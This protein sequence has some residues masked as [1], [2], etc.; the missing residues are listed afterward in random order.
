M[1]PL[2]GPPRVK[3]WFGAYKRTIVADIIDG[4]VYGDVT[5]AIFAWPLTQRPMQR[6]AAAVACDTALSQGLALPALRD[7]AANA[8]D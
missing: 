2:Q 7:R 8:K 6:I 5:E 4:I 3:G 1:L